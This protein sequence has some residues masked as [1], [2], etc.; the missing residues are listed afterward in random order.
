MF[1]RLIGIIT[2]TLGVIFT[3]FMLLLIWRIPP[4]VPGGEFSPVTDQLLPTLGLLTLA[5]LILL[6]ILKLIE[7]K[8]S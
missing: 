3:G 6:V 5:F 7:D 4:F 1:K 8:K 2:L